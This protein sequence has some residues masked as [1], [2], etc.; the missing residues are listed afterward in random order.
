LY[1]G[2]ALQTWKRRILLLVIAVVVPILANGFRVFGIV[3]LGEYRGDAASAYFHHV[4][5]GWLFFSVVTLLLLMIGSR[6]REQNEARTVPAVRIGDPPLPAES[7]VSQDD[8][9]RG[10][11]PRAITLAALGALILLASAPIALI[12]LDKVT[13]ERTSLPANSVT[14]TGPWIALDTITSEWTPQFVGTS[15]VLQRAYVSGPGRVDLYIA[16]YAPRDGTKLASSGNAVYLEPQWQRVSEGVSIPVVGRQ[17][18]RVRETVVR[19]ARTSR[20]IWSWYW[21]GGELTQSE[22]RAKYL[23]ARSRF[24]ADKR[25]GAAIAVASDFTFD[26]SEAESTLRDFLTHSAFFADS[27]GRPR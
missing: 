1:A 11:S 8:S 16:Y 19:S 3:I 15:S 10:T 24:F 13:P 5:Y 2:L 14:V 25:G 20:L 7:S 23:L 6:L 22:Y 21:V 26:R 17:P 27:R 9:G 12:S 18:V 4:T